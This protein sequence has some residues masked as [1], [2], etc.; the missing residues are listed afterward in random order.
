MKAQQHRLILHRLPPRIPALAPV[1]Y[2]HLDV[3][4]RQEFSLILLA[5]G[6]PVGK[7]PVWSNTDGN[8]WNYRFNDLPIYTSD[9][10][11]IVYTVM[12]SVPDGYVRT[13]SGESNDLVNKLIDDA[14]TL[15][16]VNGTKIWVDYSLSLIHI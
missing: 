16:T 5:D 9:G 13:D 4:K 12:E 1:S 11:E 15:T 14:K 3:Y 6:T 8:K 2:T 10:K 7:T